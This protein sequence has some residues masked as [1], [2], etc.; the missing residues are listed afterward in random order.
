MTKKIFTY[1]LLLS[2]ITAVLAFAGKLCGWIYYSLPLYFALMGAVFFILVKLKRNSPKRLQFYYVFRT[3]KLFLTVGLMAMAYFVMSKVDVL[4]V[5]L[6][7][8]YY[9]VTMVLE[10]VFFAKEFSKK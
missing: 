7:A 9:L 6:L 3:V 4:W 2:V 8:V 5:A 10:T 1:Y